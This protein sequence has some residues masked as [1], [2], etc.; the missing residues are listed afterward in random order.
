MLI[1]SFAVI[2]ILKQ[3]ICFINRG[4]ITIYNT[5]STVRFGQ[6]LNALIGW[7]TF[8]ALYCIYLQH[9]LFRFVLVWWFFYEAI[10]WAKQSSWVHAI[11][12]L[13]IWLIYETIP[14]IPEH[15]ISSLL[16]SFSQMVRQKLHL[17]LLVWYH[18]FFIIE[19][20]MI[21]QIHLHMI[22]LSKSNLINGLLF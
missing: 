11:Q 15:R 20:L 19:Y 12:W 2:I 8:L 17:L 7:W 22:L 18:V 4:M 5:I 6:E 13:R 9:V 14:D 10:T 16:V 1:S 21:N 3:L